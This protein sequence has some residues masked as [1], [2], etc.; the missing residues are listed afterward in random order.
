MKRAKHRGPP[1]V[2]K[3][4]NPVATSPLLRKGGAHG[5]SAGAT[6]R[7]EKIALAKSLRDA[8]GGE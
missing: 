6:R 7:L 5:K 2:P 8:E 3:P 4:R 1:T